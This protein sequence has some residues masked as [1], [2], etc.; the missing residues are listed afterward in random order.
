MSSKDIKDP[1]LALNVEVGE[2]VEVNYRERGALRAYKG[3]V[4]A[5]GMF[6]IIKLSPLSDCCPSC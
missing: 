3:V 5:T 1:E 4:L 2:T 6:L